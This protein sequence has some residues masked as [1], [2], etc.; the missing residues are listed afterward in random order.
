MDTLTLNTWLVLGPALVLGIISGY[1]SE[2]V[3]IVNIAINGTMTFGALFFFIFSNVFALSIPA[4]NTSSTYN[5]TFLASMLISVLLSIPVGI[6]FAFAAIK[7]KADHVIAGT[8]INLLSTG[9]GM[10]INDRASYLF[11]KTQLANLYIPSTSVNGSGIYLEYIICF[12]IALLLVVVIYVIMNFS[13]TGLRYRAIGENP[14]AVDAQG[15]NVFKY[16]WLG[17][18]FA[19]LVAGFAGSLFGFSRSGQ[20]FTGD[21]NGLG[22]IALALLIVSSWKILPGTVLGL[23]FALLLAYT[24]SQINLGSSVYLLKMTPFLLTIIVMVIFGRFNLGPKA[25]GIHFDKGLK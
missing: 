17:I 2:R 16:Q 10:I 8:G 6:L 4:Y 23:V 14:N 22:F 5:W 24:Q 13:R 1:M 3:G 11:K 9:I 20:S 15:I 21:V 19:T 12:V 25:S 18:I 7:L